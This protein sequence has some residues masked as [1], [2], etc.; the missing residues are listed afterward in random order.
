MQPPR[1]DRPANSRIAGQS[2]SQA[3]PP[4]G[5]YGASRAMPRMAA[6]RAPG[7]DFRFR[8]RS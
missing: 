7:L 6:G 3:Y 1:Q 4:E 2:M 5:V 8:G